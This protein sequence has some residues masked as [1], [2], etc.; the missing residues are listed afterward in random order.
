MSHMNMVSAAAI[1]A[2]FNR[3]YYAEQERQGKPPLER[4]TLGHLP[5]AHVAGVMGYFVHPFYEAGLVYWMPGFDFDR[6]LAYCRDLRITTFFTVPPIFMAIAKHPAVKDQFRHMRNA[7]SGAAP[8]TADLQEAASKKM[9]LTEEPILQTWG[10]S[11]TTGSATYM[12][13]GRKVTMGSLSPLLPNVTM[14]YVRASI[15]LL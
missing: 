15:P 8:L 12:P 10:M 1:P 13:P 5:T 11:E 4:R 7:V 14:R 9:G 3:P 6:F 2:T